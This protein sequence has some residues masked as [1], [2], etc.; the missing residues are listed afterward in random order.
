MTNLKEVKDNLQVQSFIKE[1]E[2]AMSALGFTNHGF[3][4]SDIVA[5][6]AREISRKIGLPERQQELCAV[7][8][9]CHDM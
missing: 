5:E 7:A 8:G 2:V 6:R 1:S 3:R 9:Y 4:H